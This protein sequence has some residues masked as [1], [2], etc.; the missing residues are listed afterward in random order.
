MWRRGRAGGPMQ[1]RYAMGHTALRV[2]RSG[3]GASRK[4]YSFL[5]AL[6]EA[7]CAGTNSMMPASYLS[8]MK[9]L[10]SSNK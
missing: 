3:C 7:Y 9:R 8:A 1:W 5:D 2:R 6:T 10:P 4:S